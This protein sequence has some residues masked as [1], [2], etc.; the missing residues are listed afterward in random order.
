[1]IRILLCTLIFSTLPGLAG[2]AISIMSI[3][4]S[5]SRRGHLQT[6]QESFQSAGIANYKFVGPVSMPGEPKPTNRLAYGGNTL[7]DMLNGR[8][9][10][11]ERYPSVSDAVTTYR[12]DIVLLMGGINNIVRLKNGEGLE[13]TEQAWNALADYFADQCPETT[14]F[15]GGVTP[16][17]SKKAYA[18]KQV[19][20]DRFNAYLEA[21]VRSRQLKG[22]KL[23]YVDTGSAFNNSDFNADGLH[24]NHSGD[25][26]IGDAWF[27]VLRNSSDSPL[28]KAP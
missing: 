20:I 8:I 3:G 11:G 2:D 18:S 25:V 13:E 12:P 26:K 16:V 27:Q 17:N 24:P 10:N 14:V 22:Q 19:L 5:I 4:D 28:K 7:E 6:L 23:I 9:L 21:E 15:I 1:M